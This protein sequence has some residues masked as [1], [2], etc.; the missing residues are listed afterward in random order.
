MFV[1]QSLVIHELLSC[2]SILE[3]TI[4]DGLT[5]SRTHSHGSLLEAEGM[6]PLSLHQSSLAG[7]HL[8]QGK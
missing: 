7:T 5:A 8:A 2:S 1:S 6:L 4:V 3:S